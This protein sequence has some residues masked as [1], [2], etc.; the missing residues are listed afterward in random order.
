MDLEIVLP[1]EGL[2]QVTVASF[3][4]AIPTTVCMPK[5]PK[6]SFSKSQNPFS[7]LWHHS[8]NPL[9]SIKNQKRV[10]RPVIVDFLKMKTKEVDFWNL[11]DVKFV[12]SN[13]GPAKD[14]GRHPDSVVVE[15]C[16]VAQRDTQ[17]AGG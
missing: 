8:Q 2:D 1:V 5:M 10:S 16:L 11:L 14:L 13:S 7:T 4:P 15:A 12:K 6:T 3:D 17:K 9:K